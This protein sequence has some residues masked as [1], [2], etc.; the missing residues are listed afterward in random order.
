MC[1][2]LESENAYNIF[3]SLN[4]TGVPLGPSDLIRNFV[5]M[6]VPPDD[7][8]AFDEDL[9]APLED[10][11]ARDDGT[12]DE[13]QLSRFFR[14]FLMADGRYVPPR[15]AFG[16]FEARYEAT[17]FLPRALAS[18]LI[19]SARWYA[20]ISG[21]NV[22][23]AEE[24]SR[25]L[26][27]LNALDSST[28][29]PLL[30]ALFSRRAAGGLDSAQLARCIE[31]LRGFILRRFVCGESSRGYG[32]MFVRALANDSGDPVATLEAYLLERG[33]PA[34]QRFEGAFAE[35]PLYQRGYTKPVLGTLERARGHKE[36]A[37]LND[38][39][40]EHI[41]PQ[42]LSPMWRAMLGPDAERIHGTWLHRPGNLTLSAYNQEL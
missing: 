37:D 3:K 40:V 15:D 22:D 17:G 6:H 9:W 12:L 32:P 41:L 7:H 35:F 31:M 13:D 20:V 27:G 39:Q 5:F 10:L 30:L 36:P 4:S 28:T 18:T 34:D 2:T 19:E 14:D 29:Y 21:Q 25:A 42:T 1:A 24:V 8:D 23:E 33:W 38:A 26:A 16:S 11:F